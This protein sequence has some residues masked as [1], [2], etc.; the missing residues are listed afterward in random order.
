MATS[1]VER[2]HYA[3][4]CQ[5]CVEIEKCIEA[6]NIVSLLCWSCKTESPGPKP[7]MWNWFLGVFSGDFVIFGDSSILTFVFS[8]FSV[9]S[10]FTPLLVNYNIRLVMTPPI[11]STSI[12]NVV[13]LFLLPLFLVTIWPPPVSFKIWPPLVSF[14]ICY[15]VSFTF[16]LALGFGTCLFVIFQILYLH[17]LS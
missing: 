15:C 1:P 6:P 10:S 11:V 9:V 7:G 16:F 4:E 14:T 12:I 8:R 13:L 17:L 2:L 3:K 5:Y